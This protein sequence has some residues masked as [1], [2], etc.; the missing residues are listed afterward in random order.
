M[1]PNLFGN[2]ATI[3]LEASQ[4]GVKQEKPADL[5]IVKQKSKAPQTPKYKWNIVWRNVIAFLYLHIGAMYGIYLF[6]SKAKF[7][8]FLWC[9]DCVTL[10]YLIWDF[11]PHFLPDSFNGR[12][13]RPCFSRF[14]TWFFLFC[15]RFCGHV[16]GFGHYSRSAQ[17]MGAQSVQSQ[18]ALEID[19]HYFPNRRIPGKHYFPRNDPR[20]LS[21]EI[22]LCQSLTNCN[23]QVWYL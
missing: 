21:L 23:F 8:T 1:A 5:K 10:L 17:I 16:G 12:F 9:K 18:M 11:F 15:S 22:R 3:F 7:L 13:L 19:P 2:S 4:Q 14:L 20:S 6:T